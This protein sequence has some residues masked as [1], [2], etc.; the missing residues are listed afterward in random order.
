ML[1]TQTWLGRPV[2][3]THMRNCLSFSK[4]SLT[5]RQ[6]KMSCLPKM[7]FKSYLGDIRDTILKVF[8]KG[9]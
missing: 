3:C 7:Y 2:V 6:N 8:S 4:V 1:H 9:S 5:G